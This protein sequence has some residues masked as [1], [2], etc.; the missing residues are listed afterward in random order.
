LALILLLVRYVLKNISDRVD[1][2]IGFFDIKL[3][4]RKG[5]VLA[6]KMKD[7]MPHQKFNS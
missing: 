2:F 4:P 7:K 3:V 5:T 6:N 1:I